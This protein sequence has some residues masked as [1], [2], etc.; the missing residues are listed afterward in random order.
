MA[1]NE[2]NVTGDLDRHT[3]GVRI[4]AKGIGRLD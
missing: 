1:A 4:W 3:D 2:L